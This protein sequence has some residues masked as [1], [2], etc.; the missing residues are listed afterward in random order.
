MQNKIIVMF[1]KDFRLY[2]NPALFEAVQ[3]GE[4]LPVYIQE[5]TFS[6]GSASKWWLHHAV[7]DV[8]KQLEALGS[9]L[10]IRKG[11]TEEEILSLIEQLD[12]TAV[13][14]NICY[15]PD[16]LQSNQKMKMMLEDKGIICKEFNSHLLLE[17]W[18]IKKKDNTEYKVFTP[19]TMHFKSR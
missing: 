15:D 16:R 17:P 8:K 11:R 6:I 2:D 10:I 5:E 18:I 19:F 9:T 12:I 3:S 4:V 1:Q 7:I 13:Y 14:W